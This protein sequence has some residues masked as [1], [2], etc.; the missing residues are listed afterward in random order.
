MKCEI[1]KSRFRGLCL[2]I[3]G[4]C[5]ALVIFAL[6][7]NKDPSRYVAGIVTNH[8]I[9]RGGN[10]VSISQGFRLF[11]LGTFSGIIGGLMG[12]GGGV[13]KVYGLYIIFGQGLLLARSVSIITN[14]FIY[15]TASYKHLKTRGLVIKDVVELMIPGAVLGLVFGFLFGNIISVA[16]LKTLLGLFAIYCGLSMLRKIYIGR[17]TGNAD[18]R[19]YDPMKYKTESKSNVAGAGFPMGA[20]MGLFGIS[21]GVFG[22]PYQMRFL[23]MP[24]KHAI[25]NT[26]MTSLVASLI[27]IPLIF[28]H[29]STHG[30]G[31]AKP[32]IMAL[33]IVPGN[34]VGSMLGSHLTG[35]LPENFIRVC[36]V[37][38]MLVIGIQ[39]FF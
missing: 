13:V 18:L 23:K 17:S 39:L 35:V 21:G 22:I 8:S 5:I 26:S 24:I 32:I 3:F 16:W 27:A 37:F 19:H 36:Y 25:A 14:V 12:M 10:S 33:W 15:G 9:P 34:I 4:V 38:I 20:V 7:V 28:W 2:A 1:N 6:F 29:E 30:H 31:I 11:L